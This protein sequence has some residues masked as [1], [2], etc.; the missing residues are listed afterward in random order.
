M[1]KKHR[2]IVIDD[3]KYV[4]TIIR[5]GKEQYVQVWK[6]KKQYFSQS[7]RLSGVTPADIADAI[8]EYNE[9]LRQIELRETLDVEWTAFLATVP[10]DGYGS[11]IAESSKIF[12][13]KR[14]KWMQK[15][16]KKHG[17]TMSLLL[18]RYKHD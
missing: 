1:E 16:I 15:M 13:S 12:D 8:K 11:T 18:I 17:C 4:W 3:I 6:D 9:A 7:F 14:R 10:W 2:D 5:A